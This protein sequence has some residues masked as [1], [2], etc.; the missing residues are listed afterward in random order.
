MYWYGLL[1]ASTFEKQAAALNKSDT[2]ISSQTS[3]ASALE[4]RTSPLV[5]E[6]V[7]VEVKVKKMK[8]ITKSMMRVYALCVLIPVVWGKGW[9]TKPDADE[10]RRREHPSM[11]MHQAENVEVHAVK[12]YPLH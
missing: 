9:H 4:A 2:T 6:L 11:M 12:F 7:E 3:A 8:I 1:V 5:S 10:S